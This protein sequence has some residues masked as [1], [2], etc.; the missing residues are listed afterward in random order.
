MVTEAPKLPITLPLKIRRADESYWIEDAAG[1]A[2][3]SVPFDDEPSRR[4]QTRRFSE[5]E[6][7]E[8]AQMIARLL[9]DVESEDAGPNPS[10]IPIE[11]LNAENDE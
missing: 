6:A 5:D 8:I 2:V 4:S 9:M 11:D 1:H 7:R 10:T 3:A